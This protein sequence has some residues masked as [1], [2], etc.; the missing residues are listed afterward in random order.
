MQSLFVARRPAGLVLAEQMVSIRISGRATGLSV[1]LSAHAAF[2][3]GSFPDDGSGASR[4]SGCKGLPTSPLTIAACIQVA[5]HSFDIGP[6]SRSRTKGNR[7]LS[8]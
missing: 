6:T 3:I 8:D 4:P 7:R 5:G 2:H 1:R